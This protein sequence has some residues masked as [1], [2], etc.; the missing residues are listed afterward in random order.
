MKKYL[1]NSSLW[2]VLTLSLLSS[3]RTEDGLTQKQ[4]EKD[5]RFSVLIPKSGKSVNYADGFAFLMKKYDNVN[6][7]NI[8]GIHNTKKTNLNA[9]ISPLFQNTGSYI[10]FKV[11]SFVMTEENGE[12]WVIF[13]RV[14][15]NQVIG[16]I[17]CTLKEKETLIAFDEI[18][19][20]SDYY[21]Q[22]LPLFQEAFNRY[23]R[24]KISLSL[25]A[26]IKPMA[27]GGGGETPGGCGDDVQ[28][29]GEIEEV[30]IPGKPKEPKEPPSKP[31]GSSACE[32]ISQ[33]PPPYDDG[34]G[35][36]GG[37]YNPN[38]AAVDKIDVEQLKEYPCAYAVAQELPNLNNDIAKLLKD[39]FGK[40][41]GIN[42]TFIPADLEKAD[43]GTDMEG[44]INL[45]KATISLDKG[46]LTQATQEYILATMYH[47]VVHAYL[48]FEQTR[49]GVSGFNA[50]YPGVRSYDVTMKDGTTS[51]KFEFIQE[52]SHNRMGPFING[53]KDSILK[54]SPNYPPERAEALAMWGIITEASIPKGYASYNAHERE[55]ST[56]ALGK[57][58]NK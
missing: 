56:A 8:S 58:C 41:N 35:G 53:L 26:S 1:L 33:C 45:F 24:R 25:N 22:L 5:M 57:K 15:N 34:S 52:Q 50:S 13:P 23:N 6:G 30:V 12:K 46:M 3:C 49:L 43:G 28:Q 7:T 17:M 20:D 4:Q 9:S 54:F 19:R 29:C 2:G 44:D 10:E 51:K 40:D 42:V 47:E 38:P 18:K 11:R 31:I 37:D 32:S 48:L 39:T 27:L 14:E 16:L 55:S 21:K 36:D